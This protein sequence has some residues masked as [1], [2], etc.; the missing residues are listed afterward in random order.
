MRRL[1][2]PA[3]LCLISTSVA[4][5]GGTDGAPSSVQDEEAVAVYSTRGIVRALP[6]PER[7][8]SEMHIRHEALPDFES[9]DGEVVGMK[10][11]T[12]PFPIDSSM[13]EGVALGDRVSFDFEVRW[14]GSPPMHVTRLDVLPS[15]TVL[16]FETPAAAP[17]P[18][19]D[20]GEDSEPA[21][22]DAGTSDSADHATHEHTH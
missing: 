21:E 14:N 20:A 4:G 13:L 1:L 22:P 6:D 12:M 5:C 8:G 10:S 16:S 19:A 2:L 18:G 11:M 7:P 15:D 17:D 9:I 3:L